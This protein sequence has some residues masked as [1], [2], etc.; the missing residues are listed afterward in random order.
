MLT[1]PPTKSSISTVG[2][3]SSTWEII[4]PFNHFIIKSMKEGL[5]F[6]YLLL[7][8]SHQ[9]AGKN[10][11][12]IDMSWQPCSTSSIAYEGGSKCG[13]RRNEVLY[14]QIWEQIESAHKEER[15]LE[16]SCLPLAFVTAT[17]VMF[18]ANVLYSTIL[19][20]YT[21]QHWKQVATY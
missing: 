20:V 9:Q 3:R 15:R 6:F 21:P 19:F 7:K 11:D 13:G 2:R 12:I 18:F 17:V 4:T 16:S 1:I 14:C 5:W 8:L 10:Q